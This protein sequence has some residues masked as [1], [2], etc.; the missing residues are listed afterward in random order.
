MGNK[1]QPITKNIDDETYTFYRLS[2]RHST[3][4]LVK[5]LKMLGPSIGSGFKEEK[6]KIRSV[7]DADIDIGK[8]VTTFFDKFDIDDV[9][10]IIDVLFTQVNH[11]GEGILSNESTYNNLFTGRQKHLYKVLFAS[12][13]V[14]YGNFFV[15]NRGL[16]EM[17]KE[18]VKE[19]IQKNQP[20]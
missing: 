5:I 12:L 10:G 7:L 2:P 3:R 14:E 15:G 19:V 18:I 8:I 17:Y 11:Q 4:I 13:E 1:I 20:M 6:I 9:Q 16:G